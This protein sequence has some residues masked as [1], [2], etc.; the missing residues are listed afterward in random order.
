M[1]PIATQTSDSAVTTSSGQWSLSGC[2]ERDSTPQ[3]V[4]VIRSPFRIGRRPDLELSLSSSVVSGVHAELLEQAGVLCIRDRGSTNGTFVNGRRISSDTLLSEGDWIEV[5]DV[6]MKVDCSRDSLPRPYGEA[7]FQKTSLFDS[8]QQQQSARGLQTLFDQRQ[9]EACFQP[10][11]CLRSHDIYGYE[12]LAR[13]SVDGVHTPGQMFAAAEAC[14]REV[15]L[16]MLC[17]EMGVAHSTGLPA[18]L[19]L[20][21]NTHPHEPLLEEVVPQLQKLRE[22]FPARPLVLELHEA[23][24]TEP[25]LVRSVRSA[26]TEIGVQL[27]FDDFGSGQARI[28]ELI[29]APSDYIK[30]DAALIRDLQDVSREQFRLFC[31]IIS[32]VQAEGAITV[33]EGVETEQMIELC[34]ET[35][36]DL[37]Q[38]YA[39]SRPAIIETRQG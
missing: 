31:S 23:A 30:F 26:L 28:R 37:L 15:E 17:R 36:F 20:F 10:I 1:T 16:S 9:L 8:A 34:V 7:L 21:L 14:G 4:P 2:F 35:G 5:G 25:G 12:Y 22:Q 3:C 29:C 24:I 39:L 32:G 38:G 27:A 19:P 6:H 13:S 11:H 18:Q 33:A